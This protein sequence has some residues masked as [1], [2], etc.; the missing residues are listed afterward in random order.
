MRGKLSEAALGVSDPRFLSG[1]DFDAE[2]KRLTTQIDFTVGVRVP[3][4]EVAGV[5]FV[6]DTVVERYRDLNFFGHDCFLEARMPRVEP[7]RA[8][9]FSGFT[10]LFDAIVLTL[11]QQM[12]FAAAARVVGEPWHRVH[13]ICKRYVELTLAKIDQS[14]MT[15]T[16]DSETSVGEHLSSARITFDKLHVVAQASFASD[17]KIDV[18]S[19]MFAQWRTDAMRFRVELRKDMARMIDTHFD[20]IVAWTQTRQTNGVVG[21]LNRWFHAARRRAPSYVNFIVMR[22]VLVLTAGKLDFASIKPNAA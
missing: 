12:P 5:H 18:V 15:D 4:L 6:H 20:G 7:G 3:Y 8:R 1:V 13:A 2:A 10:L 14:G 9:E 21:T 22:T 17:K 16:A 11:A 19:V